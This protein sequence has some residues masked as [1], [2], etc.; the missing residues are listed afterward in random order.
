MVDLGPA[1]PELERFFFLG[2]DDRHLIALCRTDAPRLYMAVQVC[3]LRTSAG[4]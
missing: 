2:D 1:R 3:K 4:S